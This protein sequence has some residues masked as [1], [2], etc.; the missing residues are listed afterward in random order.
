MTTTSAS[1]GRPRPWLGG[2]VL[3]LVAL[4]P[5]VLGLETLLT[6]RDPED[7]PFQRMVVDEVTGSVY[8]GATNRLH[9]LSP[10]LTLLQSAATGRREDNPDCP[11]PVVPCSEPKVLRDGVTK[12]LVIDYNDKTLIVCSTLYH[13]S[14]Q[15]LSLKN[16]TSV[17]RLIH[18]PLVP[19]RPGASCVLFIGP[20]LE[21]QEALYVGAEYSSLGNKAYRDL[22]PSISSRQLTDLKLMYRDQ[23]GGT[24]KSVLEALRRSFHVRH[25]HGFTRGGFA[26][27]L[28]VQR[29][30][31]SSSSLVSKVG[32]VCTQDKYFRSY[33]EIPLQ[34]RVKAATLHVLQAADVDV[35]GGRVVGVFSEQGGARGGAGQGEGPSALCV[36]GLDEVDA[37]LNRT[38]RECYAGNGRVGP[39]HYEASRSCAKTSADVDMCAS[40][41]VSEA[42][43][44]MEGQRAVVAT[45]VWTLPGQL[46]TAVSLQTSTQH[47]VVFVGSSGG[48]VFKVLIQG[49]SGHA[50]DQLTVDSRGPIVQIRPSTNKDHL[51]VLSPSKVSLLWVRHCEQRATCDECVADSDPMCGWCVMQNK[52]TSQPD[53]DA[54]AVTPSW[55]PATSATCAKM[56][57]V[58]PTVVSY[59]SLQ[60]ALADKQI[61]FQLEQVSVQPSNGLDLGCLFVSGNS[62]HRT[63]ATVSSNVI[64]CPL[65]KR[66]HLPRIPEDHEDM[67]LHFHVQGKSIVT[68]SVA[69]FDCRSNP[70]CGSCTNSSYQCQWCYASGSCIQQSKSCPKKGSHQDSGITSPGAC[71]LVWTSSRDKDILVHAGEKRQIAVQVRNLQGGQTSGIKCHFSYLGMETSVDGTISSQSLTCDPVKFDYP[72]KEQL[73]YVT[74]DFKVTW[75]PQSLPLDNSQGIQVRIYKCSLL[76]TNCGKCLS[77]DAE[78]ECG[79]CGSHCTLQKH[80]TTGNWLDR[81]AT[82][83]GPQILRFSPT[84]GPIK[85][86]T[87]MSVTGLNLGKTYSDI[88]GGVTVAG[89]K[90]EVKPEHYEPSSGF[91]C[92]TEMTDAVKNGTITVVVDNLYTAESDSPFTYVDPTV[93]G[94]IPKMGPRSGGT[95]LVIIGTHM[96]AGSDVS[97]DIDGGS[98]QVIKRN[99]TM[100]E[101]IV[102]KQ[103][104]ASNQARVKV[105][106]GGHEKSSPEP[107]TYANDPNISMIEPK[108]S[109]L[110]GG[111]SITVIGVG[112]DLIQ[113]PVFFITYGGQFFKKLCHL[114]NTLTMEC[115]VPSL[116]KPIQ[117]ANLNITETSPLEVHYG[118]TLDGVMTHKNISHK[119]EFGPLLLYPDPQLNM[120]PGE[121]QTKEFTEKDLLVINGRFRIISNL[122]ASVSVHVG[123]EEC[124]SVA[125]TDTAITC[126]P[127]SSAPDGTESTGIAP[128]MVRIGNMAKKVG[129][130][131]YY[132]VSNTNK[133]MA[134]GVILGVVIPILAIIVLLTV[135]VLRR[136]RK[137]KPA[138]DYIPDVLQ[139]YQGKKEEE[140]IGLNHVAVAD[141]NG[142]IM[143]EKDCS[144]YITELLSQFEDPALRQNVTAMLIPRSRLDVGELIG[145]GHFGAV[146]KAQLQR[147]DD[148]SAQVAVKTLQAKNS[149]S[150]A[151]QNFLKEV[152]VVNSLQHPHLLAVAGVCLTASDDPMVVSP[153][154]ATEDLKSY[155]GEPSKALTVLEL[156]SFGQQIADGMAY[157]QEV[158]VVHRNLAARNCIVTEDGRLQLTDYGI[159]ASLFPQSYYTA[160]DSPAQQLVKWMAPET[161]EN[162]DFTS[163]SDVWAFGVVL[164]ELLTRGITPYPDVENSN[165]LPYLKEG[166]RM[167]KPRQ[168]PEPVYTMM[169]ACW[170]A[171]PDKRPDFAQLNDQLKNFT[172]ADK[173]DSDATAL[174]NDS[175]DVGGSTEYLEVIG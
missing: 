7:N 172:V 54:S 144:P 170:D 5:A 32:R 95:T 47:Q 59:E 158:K 156:L 77:M 33:V 151:I 147:G 65:P 136:H 104:G 152:V 154:M 137:H 8:V 28:T 124:E 57:N 101:C 87:S 131:R 128:V 44:S 143:D 51:Y 123:N 70:D 63:K 30:S 27:F 132:E 92:E 171:S 113:K 11:P 10:G 73:P 120:F 111:T 96:D 75:G 167:K 66:E 127:P 37:E 108:R 85:G 119:P 46:A 68:R 102:P 21:G 149:D 91:V 117:A 103:S 153:F 72:Q 4:C 17:V 125:A 78:Y 41:D 9:R 26:Y 81:T 36:L 58:R 166:R 150:E 118:F 20:S 134:L 6:F 89:V 50:V 116:M 139:D 69:V 115:Q 31:N 163:K 165:L 62:N 157:L 164:W 100:L 173:G 48:D 15:K 106:F 29:E 38:V 169:V 23:D 105:S 61:S 45:G 133:P 2:T 71:P 130:L 122:M 88:S 99:R 97:I 84:T 22:I 40:G 121:D 112:L 175:V 83:P 12:G 168:S 67:V 19:N 141:V 138:T 114:E 145:K 129:Y 142:Q 43:P 3:M 16:I 52:C 110:S 34:C 146:Y 140:E 13:G 107:F 42:Y 86:K 90:C 161:I 56:T 76:V 55:L 94:I 39:P 49:V 174:L 160:Q 25:V 126:E 24:K 109:I 14:C 60:S 148:K 82:C 80:C 159:T 35:S 98:C 53:C 74:A 93:T 64:S 1:A 79:W 155:I 135:C 162:F 18:K